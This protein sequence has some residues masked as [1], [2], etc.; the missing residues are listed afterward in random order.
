MNLLSYKCV[1]EV[2][3]DAPRKVTTDLME[4]L[5]VSMV[6][7]GRFADESR[8]FDPY[9]VPKRMNKFDNIDSGS[10]VTTEMIIDRIR[11]HGEQY[12]ATN[13]LKEENE[14]KYQTSVG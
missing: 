3:I 4:H 9:E 7:H 13:K 12:H 10:D 11:K 14:C 5:N 8:E 6:Y 2:F 1:D